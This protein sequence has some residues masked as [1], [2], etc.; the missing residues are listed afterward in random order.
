MS[1]HVPASAAAARWPQVHASWSAKQASAAAVS[2]V[3]FACAPASAS[4]APSE[5][6]TRAAVAVAV[7]SATAVVATRGHVGA[8]VTDEGTSMLAQARGG[9]AEHRPRAQ[10]VV[11]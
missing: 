3:A 5:P 6:R 4:M 8:V 2:A 10:L 11:Q 7:W 1:E 9:N